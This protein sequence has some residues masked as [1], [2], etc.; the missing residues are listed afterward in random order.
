ML[1]CSGKTRV[2]PVDVVNSETRSRMMRSVRGKH[3][4][5]EMVVRRTAHG[6]GYRYRLHCS[7]LPG[8]PDLVFASYKAA[9]FV[10]GCFWHQHSCAKG[11]IPASNSAFWQKKLLRNV[12]RDCQ[13]HSAL[14]QN[15]WKVLVVWECETRDVSRLRVLLTDFLVRRGA[16]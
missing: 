6:L 16:K 4:K 11:K 1:Q 8:R 2:W 13:A 9:I 12:E 10:N 7:S 14:L 5:P 3:T 15:G